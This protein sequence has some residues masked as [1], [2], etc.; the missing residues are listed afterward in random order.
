[1]L[2]ELEK[3]SIQFG[4]RRLLSDVSLTLHGGE[5]VALMGPSGVGKSTLLQVISKDL[6]PH[7]GVVD[8]R[9][10]VLVGWVVQSAALLPLR[11]ALDNVALGGLS[12][13]KRAEEASASAMAAMA[14]LGVL[15]LATQAVFELSGGERQRL[16]VARAMSS[17]SNLILADE[18]TASVDARSRQLV[19]A[20]LRHAASDGA[21]VVIATHDEVVSS[22]CD[23]V[24]R[25]DRVTVL[26]SSAH[27]VAD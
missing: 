24:L 9:S 27:V 2:V 20:A 10:D 12:M 16:A 22:Q 3:V 1:M 11:T 5:M 23:R 19:C 18:P 26:A 8:H 4:T 14:T 17:A 25:L 7:S 6:P 21:A 13:G 15:P